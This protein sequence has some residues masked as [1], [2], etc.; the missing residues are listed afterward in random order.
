MYIILRGNNVSELTNLV[1]QHIKS[2]WTCLGGVACDAV[3]NGLS[4]FQAMFKTNP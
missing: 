2:G 3:P 1:N 4:L